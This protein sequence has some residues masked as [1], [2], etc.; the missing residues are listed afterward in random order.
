MRRFEQTF[1]KFALSHD[2]GEIYVAAL[3]KPYLDDLAQERR[4]HGFDALLEQRQNMPEE[5]ELPIDI[6]E[7]SFTA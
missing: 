4:S 7:V 5:A 1:S 2:Y 6:V 3:I